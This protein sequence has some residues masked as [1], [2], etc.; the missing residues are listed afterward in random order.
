LSEPAKLPSPEEIEQ[1]A[2]VLSDPAGYAQARLRIEL[3]PKQAAV[4]R[5]IFKKGSHVSFRCANEVG[6]TSHVAATAILFA[7]EILNA[8]AISTAGV[9]MQVAEQLIPSLKRFS[10]MF[11]DW[12]FLDSSIS[13]NGVDRYVG[14]STRDEGFAQG[15]HRKDGMPLLAIVDEAAAVSDKV[16]NGVEDR[17]N[18][19]YFLVMGSPLDPTGQFYRIETELARHYTHHHMSQF[20]CLTTD[21]YWID[22]AS[23]ERKIA[24]WRGK[25]NPFIQ[26]NVYGEFSQRVENAMLS[27]GEF[28]ACLANPPAWYRARDERHA[29]IDF[30]AGR[31]KNVFA[32]RVGNKT[33]IEKKWTERDT[34]ATVGECLAIF[35]ALQREYGFQ[36]HEVEADADGLGIGLIHRLREVGLPLSE[37]HGGSAPRFD[38]DNFS[39]LISEA[40]HTSIGQIIRMNHII[41]AD[42]EFRAQILTRKCKRNSTGKFQLESKEDMRSRGLESPDEA[43]AVLCAMM[44]LPRI[45][46][47]NLAGI[48]PRMADAGQSE[49][50]RLYERNPDG[51]RF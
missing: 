44:P 25:D 51:V 16:F 17:C 49:P 28:T 48:Q 11:P 39:N 43:D 19:D 23:I 7:L 14:F 46:S 3:H 33:W 42:D 1:T 5:D 29:F 6:K 15:F 45:Q 12:R 31:D 47:F 32:V 2:K 13:I 18:P 9:W 35:K 38:R 21:G 27:L 8:Q 26:S 40:W 37:F 4:L 22:P 41:P 50:D 34:M 30:A 24:K 10:H 20:D 36:P